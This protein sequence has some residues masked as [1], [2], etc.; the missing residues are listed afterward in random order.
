MHRDDGKH[1][2]VRADEKLAAFLEFGISDSRPEE[3][4]E[5]CA[6]HEIKFDKLSRIK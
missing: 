1:F 2:V 6:A 4:P 3:R 5:D